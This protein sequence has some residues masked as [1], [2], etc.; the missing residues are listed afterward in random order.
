MLDRSVPYFD[1]CMC[2]PKGSKREAPPA[3]PEGYRYKLFQPGDEHAW[4]EVETSVGEFI[5]EED[6]LAYFGREF[7]PYPALLPKRMAFILGPDGEPLATATAW[8]K[9][10]ENLGRVLMLHWVAVKPS[11]QGKGLGRAITAKAL[12]LYSNTDQ[13]IWLHTQTWSHVAV[14]LYLS[15]GFRAH[16]SAVINRHKNGFDGASRTLQGVMRPKSYARFL[17]TA[18]P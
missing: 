12:S 8:E 1:I 6:A 5:R 17:L 3:L 2:L 16:K 11:Q 18:M 13:D 7:A 10:D 15:L 14:D 4:A 9:T